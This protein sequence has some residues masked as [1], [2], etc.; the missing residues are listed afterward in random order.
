MT[1]EVEEVTTAAARFAL[2]LCR[3]VEHE[4]N[5]NGILLEFRCPFD[6]KAA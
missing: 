2:A 5:D 1:G 3:R 4:V 6:V